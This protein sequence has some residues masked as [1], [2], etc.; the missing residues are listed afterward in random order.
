MCVYFTYCIISVC[1]IIEL[2]QLV[3]ISIRLIYYLNHPKSHWEWNFKTSEKC[4]DKVFKESMR[5]IHVKLNTMQ[6]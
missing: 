3:M 4:Q 2:Q 5:E 1:A 6:F